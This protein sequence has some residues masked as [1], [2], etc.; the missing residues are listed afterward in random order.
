M[1]ANDQHHA[2]F[3]IRSGKEQ[4]IL[5]ALGISRDPQPVLTLHSSKTETQTQSLSIWEFLGASAKLWKATISFV[6]SVRMSVHPS[7]SN[8][9]APTGRIFMEYDILEFFENVEKIQISLKSDKNKGD[10]TWRPTDIFVCDFD[11]ASSLICGNKIPT[12]CNRWFLL[13]ILLFAQHV[14]GT[15]MPIIRYSKVLYN[16]LYNTLE[17]LMMGIVVPATCWASN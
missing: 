7:E 14:S 8:N 3:S 9:S 17:L 10:F 4:A 15:T 1:E 5:I 12:R 13:Q 2:A 6:F 16:H 11:R